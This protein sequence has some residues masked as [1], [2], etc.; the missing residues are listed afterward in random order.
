MPEASESE[1]MNAER[2]LTLAYE[3]LRTRNPHRDICFVDPEFEAP[4]PYDYPEGSREFQLAHIEIGRDCDYNGDRVGF[5][6]YEY[7]SVLRAGLHNWM[8]AR[9]SHGGSYPGQQYVNDLIAV[10]LEKNADMLSD[11]ELRVNLRELIGGNRYFSPPPFAFSMIIAMDDGSLNVPDSYIGR[12]LG[13][14]IGHAINESLKTPVQQSRDLI[15]LE[16]VGTAVRIKPAVTRGAKYAEC[17]V[18]VVV[19]GIESILR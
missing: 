14:M 16:T 19:Q 17:L 8:V 2:V 15:T 12:K 9:G 5:M 10:K 13:L 18:P 7:A 3:M 1:G 11:R 4:W 6:C